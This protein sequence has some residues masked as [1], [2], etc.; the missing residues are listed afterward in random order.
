MV[1]IPEELLRR[2]AEARAAATGRPVEDV[3]A[4]MVVDVEEKIQNLRTRVK[5]L[6]LDCTEL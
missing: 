1:D 6:A 3:L 5:N 2:S 4:E